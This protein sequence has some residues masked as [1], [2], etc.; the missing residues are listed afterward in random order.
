MS[1]LLTREIPETPDLVSEVLA[2]QFSI[3]ETSSDLS[4]QIDIQAFQSTFVLPLVN[5]SPIW[6]E[7]K[8]VLKTAVDEHSRLAFTLLGEFAGYAKPFK[9]KQLT[10]SLDKDSRLASSEFMLVSMWVLLALAE[11]IHLSMV[12]Q[13]M[14]LSFGFDAPLL[15]ISEML[16]R[17]QIAYR[18]MVIERATGLQFDLP[19]EISG[20]EVEELALIYHAIV[21]RSFDWPIDEIT[22]FFPATKQWQERLQ[23]ANELPSFTLGPDPV[24]KTLFGK[25]VY[26]GERTVTLLDKIIENLDQVKQELSANNGHEVPVVIRSR[27]GHGRY[28]FPSVPRLPASPWS[29]NIKQLVNLDEQLDSKLFKRYNELAA[30][31]LAGLSDD[32]K[33]AITAR[34]TI[35]EAFVIDPST[36]EN[37]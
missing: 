7:G 25:Q 11:Q 35:G 14:D 34:P 28:Q 16:R 27:S 4:L 8:V 33:I 15:E 20:E 13:R 6:N 31:T 32:E 23:S 19:V 17:R 9:I 3:P 12:D 37:L 1:T 24:H 30:A 36:A 21:D 5:I 22:V 18:M 29:E 10:L 2:A 26:L